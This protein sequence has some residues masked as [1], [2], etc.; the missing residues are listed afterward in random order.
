M[1]VGKM[2]EL[3]RTLG[4]LDAT[5][6]GIGA[7]IGAGIFVVL[8]I[9][10]GPAGPAVVVSMVIAGTVALFTA[11]SFAELGS[12]IPKQG[13]TYEFAYELISPFVAFVSGCLWLFGQ[14]VAGAAVSLGLASYIVAVFPSLSLKIVAVSA[15]VALTGLNL[16]GTR[17]SAMVNNALVL[18]KILI[19]C[20]F[21][22]FGAFQV[23]TS[24]YSQIAPN[25]LVGILQGAGLIF[26]AYVGF[27]RIAAL[28]EE[29]K[30]PKRTLPLAVLLS[31]AASVV[32]YILTGFVATGLLNYQ[33]L[34]RSGSPLAD[35]ARVT[36]NFPLV[37]AVFFGAFVAT[38][39]VLLTNLIGLGRVSF[40]MA[41]NGQLPKSLATI[42]PKLGTP[43]VSILATG[44]LMS[45]LAFVSD[46]RQTAAITSLSLLST[47]I[48]LH[49]SAIRLRKKVPELKTF[50]APFYPLIPS[51][52]LV[53]CVILMF[54]LPV[55]AWV[56]W[57][58]VVTA[59]SV[60]YLLIKRFERIHDQS[61]PA[62]LFNECCAK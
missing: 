1:V 33:A 13:G 25:G 24:N 2:V 59:V 26:F 50:K 58:G 56:V 34:A 20:A 11:V 39:S 19:L 17:R 45:I 46:L 38:V 35:A 22:G 43:Y 16:V 54:S 10:A 57:V 51:L 44:A 3:K 37:A 42:H 47:H 40:A 9:A 18:T 6:I 8:G 32:L 52:G 31:L 41:R 30:N 29:V 55:V 53:S 49:V 21:V 7:I 48:I 60:Y 28:G 4:L 5:A 12:A 62:V 14:T 36:G 61:A 27:G 23:N 15:A